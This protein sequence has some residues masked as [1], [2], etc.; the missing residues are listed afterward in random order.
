V[1]ELR[2]PGREDLYA[3]FLAAEDLGVARPDL[4]DLRLVDASDR[5]VPYVLFDGAGEESVTL[6]AVKEPASEARVLS[7]YRLDT[8]K[9]LGEE[10]APLPLR[11]LEL[12][13]AEAFFDRPARLFVRTVQGGR[14]QPP[15]QVLFAGRISRAAGRTEPVVIPLDGAFRGAVILEIDEGDN[16]PLTLKA[17]RG[18]VSVPRV[19]LKARPGPLRLVLGNPEAQ[20]PRYDIA[21]LRREVVSYSAEPLQAGGLTPNPAF[22]RRAADYLRDA[23]PTLLLWSAL[24][25]AVLALL[26]LTARLVRPGGEGPQA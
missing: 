21:A 20:A 3:V 16:A 9:A 22:R 13:F 15:E 4:A 24:L 2:V 12:D 8:P 18:A 1:R 10:S 25:A 14:R 11:R 7:R 5:Q 17:A 19:A 23:P 6:T 26:Y